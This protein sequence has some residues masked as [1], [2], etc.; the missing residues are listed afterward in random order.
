VNAADRAAYATRYRERLVRYGHD[1]RTLGWSNG[2]QE[3]RFDALLAACPLDAA[4]SIL[5]VGCGFGDLFAHLRARGWSGH[6]TG[7]DFIPDLIE[8]GRGAHPEADLRVADVS[9]LEGERFDLVIASGIFNAVLLHEDPWKNVSKTLAAMFRLCRVAAA[10]DF[11]SSYVDYEDPGVLYTE[12]E[13]VFAFAKTL[14]RRV[15]LLHDYLP[16]EFAVAIY[17]DDAV[18]PGARFRMIDGAG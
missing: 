10:S 12:P 3:L 8:V 9:E 15:R 11:I 1:P 4:G 17:R 7:V 14:T 13:R 2:R 18:M 6:Y 16:F 5:D